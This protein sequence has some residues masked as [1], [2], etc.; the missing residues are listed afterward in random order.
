[1]ATYSSQQESLFNI[2]VNYLQNPSNWQRGVPLVTDFSVGSVAYTLLQAI[3]A[4]ADQIA[5][6]YFQADNQSSILTATDTALDGIVANWGVTRKPAIAANGTF[7]FYC[8]VAA[9]NSISI[10]KGTVITTIPDDSGNVVQ[11][12]TDQTVSLPVGQT[13]VSVTATCSN[14][15]PGSAGNLAANTQLL[16]GSSVPGIDGV[17]LGTNI[18]NGVDA[19]IDDVLR[20]RCLNVIQNPQGGGTAADYQAWAIAVSGVSNATVLPLNRGNGTVDIVITTNS[21]LPSSTLISQV[22]SAI[23]AKKPVDVDALVIGPVA[24]TIAVTPSVSVL[25]GYTVSGVTSAVQ[26]AITNYINSVAVGG[27][28]YNSRMVSAVLAVAGIADCTVSMSVNGTV[29]NNV[30]LT[31]QQ[32]ANAGTITVQGM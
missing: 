26:Q 31:S 3:A 16:V 28:V 11:F 4:G 19:E 24:V 23:N 2:M 17:T 7:T 1:M 27:T 13:S 10:P 32:Q 21:G 14:P 22:Q 29:F 5:Y 8:N 15:G 12:T 30:A 9:N 18:S 25:A 20:Q 6:L